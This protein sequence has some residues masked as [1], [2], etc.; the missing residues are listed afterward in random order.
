MGGRLMAEVQ[1]KCV[2]VA[3]PGDVQAECD[4]LPAVIAEPNN[5]IASDRGLRIKLARWETDA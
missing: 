5:S 2:V 1:I 4:A 3:S